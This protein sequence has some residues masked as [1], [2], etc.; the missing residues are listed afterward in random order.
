MWVLHWIWLGKKFDWTRKKEK[1][2]EQWHGIWKE[3]ACQKP[4]A[5]VQQNIR[6]LRGAWVSLSLELTR[7]GKWAQIATF[8]VISV[9]KTSGGWTK[10]GFRAWV[11]HF[12]PWREHPF[13]A[14]SV[15]VISLFLLDGTNTAH[16]SRVSWRQTREV[17]NPP[18]R[19]KFE[20]L[21]KQAV[22]AGGNQRNFSGR[23]NYDCR[24]Q[25]Q[26]RNLTPHSELTREKKAPW[27][28]R[29]M[30]LVF[31]GEIDPC[32]NKRCPRITF[33]YT[34]KRWVVFGCR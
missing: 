23:L 24:L 31:T 18:I 19:R 2:L 14:F 22:K 6:F 13:N 34:K 10:T 27:A 16:L 15:P 33:T 30:T 25:L 26:G 32:L 12:L 29:A 7:V 20:N 8:W 17:H 5:W 4:K 11:C 9:G 21:Q 3:P 1:E 28:P